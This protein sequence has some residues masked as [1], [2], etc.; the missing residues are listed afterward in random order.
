M[1]HGLWHAMADSST[2]VMISLKAH[3]LAGV[4]DTMHHLQGIERRHFFM[5]SVIYARN[6]VVE[7][8]HTQPVYPCLKKKDTFTPNEYPQATPP[9]PHRYP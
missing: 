2:Q 5:F 4:L 6:A 3:H 1:A 7:R 9:A 8:T